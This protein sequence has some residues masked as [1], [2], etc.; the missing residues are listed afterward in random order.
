MDE[1]KIKHG[2][3]FS[4]ESQIWNTPRDLFADIDSHWHF[5]LDAACLPNSALCKKYYTPED[6]SLVQDWGTE[7][8]W[9]NPPYNDL[10]TWLS[11]AVDAYQNGATVVTLVPSRTDT[12]AFQLYAAKE[13][14]C[15]CFIK[16]R[17]KFYDPNRDPNIKQESAPFPSCLIV[18]DRDLTQAK[19]D[20]LKT[21]GLVMKNV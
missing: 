5:T 18:L 1:K 14:S 3:H 6:D 16:G 15:I 13:C 9:L 20:Y 7:I 12:H 19:I 4:S 2:V 17:L 10:K 21:L 8:V 11:K